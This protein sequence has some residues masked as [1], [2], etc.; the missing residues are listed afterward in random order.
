MLYR[1]CPIRSRN[2]NAMAQSAALA[3]LDDDEYIEY[4]RSQICNGVRYLE[5]EFI[6]L[7]LETVPS[8][9]NF[10]L[11]KTFNGNKVFKDLQKRKIIRQKQKNGKRKCR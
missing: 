9:A 8:A 10:I 2:V 5:K 1:G 11:V 6:K 3:A 4:C 7:G